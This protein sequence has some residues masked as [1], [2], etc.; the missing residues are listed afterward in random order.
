MLDWRFNGVLQS[1]CTPLLCVKR[2]EKPLCGRELGR[3]AHEAGLSLS[4]P[5]SCNTVIAAGLMRP[6]CMDITLASFFSRDSGAH[7]TEGATG[8]STLLCPSARPS[9]TRFQHRMARR[10]HLCTCI[11]MIHD[12]VAKDHMALNTKYFVQEVEF[13][14]RCFQLGPDHFLGT[15]RLLAAGPKRLKPSFIHLEL[16]VDCDDVCGWMMMENVC[17]RKKSPIFHLG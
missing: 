8:A 7:F 15:P 10:G 9:D 16:V 3:N 11:V 17:R 14:T 12:L 4:P 13:G 5:L 2:D 6:S 1:N